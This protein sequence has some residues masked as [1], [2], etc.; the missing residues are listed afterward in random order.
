[1]RMHVVDSI[2]H[3]SD[4]LFLGV[5]LGLTLLVCA[6]ALV[7]AD[8]TEP[9][10]TAHGDEAHEEMPASVTPQKEND[11]ART[12]AIESADAPTDQEKIILNFEDVD[13]RTVFLLLADITGYTVVPAPDVSGT[14]TIINPHP[15]TPQEAMRII[16]SVLEVQG[17]TIVEHAHVIKIVKASE[18]PRRPIPVLHPPRTAKD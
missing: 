13:L 16:F 12:N 5:C 17:F 8:V 10:T 15:V 4:R 6:P 9:P 1:M 3:C 11:S 18:A 7:Y 14:V 2:I